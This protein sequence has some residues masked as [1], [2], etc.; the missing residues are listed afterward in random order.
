VGENTPVSEEDTT[1]P[2]AYHAAVCLSAF[3]A[4]AHCAGV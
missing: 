2:L 4:A 3:V 1:K